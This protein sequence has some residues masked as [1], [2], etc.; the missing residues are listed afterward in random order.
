VWYD[1]YEEWRLCKFLLPLCNLKNLTIAICQVLTTG[2]IPALLDA[3]GA[4]LIFEKPQAF[5]GLI[6]FDFSSK[7]GDDWNLNEGLKLFH[8]LSSKENTPINFQGLDECTEKRI[9]RG[10]PTRTT[11]PEVEC[12]IIMIPEFSTQFDRVEYLFKQLPPSQQNDILRGDLKLRCIIEDNM[13]EPQLEVQPRQ[14][15]LQ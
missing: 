3:E 2:T 12:Q 7:Y 11:W 1:D 13:T 9:K 4:N 5:V 14:T 6:E 10:L 8:A 15:F